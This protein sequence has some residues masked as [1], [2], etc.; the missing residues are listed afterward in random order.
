MSRT[1]RRLSIFAIAIATIAILSVLPSKPASKTGLAAHAKEWMDR[2]ESAAQETPAL[3]AKRAFS[4]LEMI[5]AIGSRTSGTI[6]MKKQQ[7]MLQ[8]HFEKLGGMVLWQP[9]QSRHPETGAIVEIKNMVVQ[10]KPE[11]P[12]RVFLCTHYDTKPFP[13][14]DP[15]NPKGLFVGAN[16]GGS[17]T[18]LF[19]ELAHWMT[20]LPTN[21]GV[22]F[23]LFDAEELVFDEKRDPYFLGS[24]YFAQAYA[25]DPTGTRYRCGILLDMIGD[26]DLQLYYEENSFKFAPA[27]VKEV[28]SVA[29]KLRIKEFEPKIQHSV[30][31]DHMPLN[32]IARIPVIDLIDFDYFPR[33]GRKDKAYWHTMAD[34]P[35][36]CSGASLVKVGSVMIEWIKQQ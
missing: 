32:E 18:A 12:Q 16:D 8:A 15:K 1:V 35:D 11:I 25:N 5:C 33:G 34:T 22:D 14:M 36:K 7:D 30:R 29:R 26:S 28:W 17:G 21:V 24:T 31:D 2:D 27:L 10:W 4:Y 6:G 3:N 23:V 13:A 9:F 19:M 20:D